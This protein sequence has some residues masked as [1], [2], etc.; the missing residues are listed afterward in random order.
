M[1]GCFRWFKVG[2]LIGFT[3]F[4]LVG[5]AILGLFVGDREKRAEQ[6]LAAKEKSLAEALR[7]DGPAWVRVRL[8]LASGATHVLCGTQKCLW[9]RAEGLRR[10][11]REVKRDGV[12][13]TEERLRRFRDQPIT[14]PML[15]IG[16]NGASVKVSDW[17]GIEV[18]ED[19]VQVRIDQAAA[20][21]SILDLV[22]GSNPSSKMNASLSSNVSSNL[23]SDTNAN[24]N[25]NISSDT[26]SRL[27]SNVSSDTNSNSGS[28]VS[29]NSGL[30]MV[31]EKPFRERE[32]IRESYLL[33]GIEAWAFG[34]F[35]KGTPHVL[36]DGKFY[37]T[38]LGRE[39]FAKQIAWLDLGRARLFVRFLMVAGIISGLLLAW[40]LLHSDPVRDTLPPPADK[41]ISDQ[42]SPHA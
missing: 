23:G 38:G 22:Q 27:S 13:K 4:C 32:V 10:K 36:A 26:S 35:I 17:L 5:G 31:P 25:L 19:L 21:N 30:N 2:A 6:A 3:V 42:E 24:V 20:Q 28:N 9:M 15:M 8:E 18:C 11:T 41:P 7:E 16:A 14:A 33:D 40:T 12:W 39:R 1:S 34:E 29:S 37:L